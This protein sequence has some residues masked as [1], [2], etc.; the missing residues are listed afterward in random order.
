MRNIDWLCEND[1]ELLID[2]A[3]DGEGICRWCI[4]DE[5]ACDYDCLGGMRKW[6]EAEH[7]D[8][9]TPE[10][11][12]SAD[13]VDSNDAKVIQNGEKYKLAD[14]D[15]REKLEDVLRNHAVIAFADKE[16][17]NDGILMRLDEFRA[18]LDRQA[19]ITRRETM[20]ENSLHN[21]PYVGMVRGKQ[22][23][24]KESSDCYCGK[25]GWK[26]TDHDSYCPECGG[27]LHRASNQ[28]TS[29]SDAPKT[30]ENAENDASKYEI[31]DFGD[32]R[33]K[34]EEVLL[35]D[36]LNDMLDC[37]KE[38]TKR[39]CEWWKS[40]T[41]ELYERIMELEAELRECDEQRI[42]YRDQRDWYRDRL[43][44]FRKK[45]GDAVW[46][47]QAIARMTEVDA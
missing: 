40:R 32:T 34:L 44:E 29:Q 10:N 36:E 1:R 13:G 45:L 28:P 17:G 14:G 37:Q 47:A 41:A 3:T 33:E 23:E 25:C 30:A 20:L 35:I 43:G 27:A 18:L 5:K 9:S 11:I 26:V 31:R 24:R 38:T 6:L 12:V 4:H 42:E 7:N 19:A 46:H 8:G 22:W 21:N 2:I 15:T 16:S 39:E